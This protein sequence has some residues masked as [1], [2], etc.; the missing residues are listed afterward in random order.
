[1]KDVHLKIF[2]DRF[3]ICYTYFQ[4][5]VCYKLK[6]RDL[7]S[8]AHCL[9]TS[10]VSVLFQKQVIE[11]WNHVIQVEQNAC[12]Q[13]VCNW[14]RPMRNGFQRSKL[15]SAAYYIITDNTLTCQNVST[16]VNLCEEWGRSNNIIFNQLDYSQTSVRL[17]KTKF[18][19]CHT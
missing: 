8:A 19:S 9:L 13:Q 11:K 2:S 5:C 18:L 7:F 12:L 6:M 10:F 14:N 1:M 3:C 15:L 4:R 16:L 17:S